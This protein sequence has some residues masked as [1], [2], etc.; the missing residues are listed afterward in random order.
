[1]VRLVSPCE[2]TDIAELLGLASE[3]GGLSDAGLSRERCNRIA[4]K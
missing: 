3:S 1:M 4:G 2:M